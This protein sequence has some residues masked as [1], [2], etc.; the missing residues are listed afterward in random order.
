M[1]VR[2]VG[3]LAEFQQKNLLHA[4]SSI[5]F[6]LQEK[7][8]NWCSHFTP[9]DMC[10]LRLHSTSCKIMEGVYVFGQIFKMDKIFS[11]TV[12]LVKLF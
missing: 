1:N 2:E 6:G 12:S 11:P 4:D 10:L 8:R 5:V 9:M 7:A 3:D